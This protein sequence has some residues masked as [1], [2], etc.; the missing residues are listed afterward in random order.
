[1]RLQ[2]DGGG[3]MRLVT[4]SDFD[5]S[6]CAALLLELGLIEEILFVHPKDLQDNKI[7]VGDRDILANVP[8][9]CGCGMWFD[10]HSSEC[11]RLQLKGVLPA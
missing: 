11:E 8:Y 4:R 5:G 9:V 3:G 7:P 1:M 10:H 6:V 2:S